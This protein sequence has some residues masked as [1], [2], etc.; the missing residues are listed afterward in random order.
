MCGFIGFIS[1]INDKRISLYE[2]KFEYYL[3]QLNNRGPDYTE[4]KKIFLKDKF[5]KVGFSRL[6]I[7][8]LNSNANR[9]FYNDNAILL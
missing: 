3:S 2:E 6:A 4:T 5:I 1:D 9:I 8:D 7:Q